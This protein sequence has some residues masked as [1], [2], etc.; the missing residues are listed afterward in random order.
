MAWCHTHNTVFFMKNI[1]LVLVIVS[2]TLLSGCVTSNGRGTYT[3]NLG[4]LGD[5]V[6]FGVVR[7][8]NRIDFDQQ[9]VAARKGSERSGFYV[10][11]DDPNIR[12]EVR[13]SLYYRPAPWDPIL[14]KY[15]EPVLM[16]EGTLSSGGY[17]VSFWQPRPVLVSRNQFIRAKVSFIDRTGREV[18]SRMTEVGPN[19]DWPR[20]DYL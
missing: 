18:R 19:E 16:R 13:W 12:I 17:G 3:A 20:T 5:T 7:D 2:A 6:K 14:R 15:R 9:E 8:P 4:P 1:L 11:N 10:R